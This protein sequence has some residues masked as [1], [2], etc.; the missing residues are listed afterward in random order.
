[1]FRAPD[2]DTWGTGEHL[3]AAFGDLDGD[4][5]EDLVRRYHVKVQ[6]HSLKDMLVTQILRSL[7]FLVRGRWSAAPTCTTTRTRNSYNR[8]Y[9]RLYPMGITARTTEFTSTHIV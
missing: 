1:M 5:D 7:H 2:E 8:P 3:A 6:Y 9:L 4:G